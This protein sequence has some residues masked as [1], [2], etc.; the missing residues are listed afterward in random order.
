M[1][2]ALFRDA[3]S[4]DDGWSA[5]SAGLSAQSGA[6]ASEYAVK[7][8]GS[9]GGGLKRHRSQEVTEEVVRSADMIVAMTNRHVQKL[10]SRFPEARDRLCLMRSFDPASPTGSDVADPFCG[11]FSDYQAC[12][13]TLRNAMPGLLAFLKERE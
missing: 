3:V 12:C 13:E 1:A 2:E 11:S 4:G 6:A 9:C 5:R 7:V 10:L 8:I